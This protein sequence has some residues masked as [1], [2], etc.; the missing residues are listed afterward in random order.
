MKKIALFI[1]LLIVSTEI[2]SFDLGPIDVFERILADD[3]YNGTV[4][5][6]FPTDIY[7]DLSYINTDASFTML[8]D[9]RIYGMLGHTPMYDPF[10]NTTIA[11]KIAQARLEPDNSSSSIILDI[12]DPS[13]K[14]G[15]VFSQGFPGKKASDMI[16]TI[17][18]CRKKPYIHWYRTVGPTVLHIGGNDIN[19]GMDS[20]YKQEG[21][22]WIFRWVL[23]FINNPW[24]FFLNIFTGST[25]NFV[26]A[27]WLWNMEALARKSAYDTG[28]VAYAVAKDNVQPVM[29]VIPAI[30]WHY[31]V[32][33]PNSHELM[34]Q[35]T[36]FV[37]FNSI[38]LTEIAGLFAPYTI[39]PRPLI[40]FQNM[41][42][43]SFDPANYN[44]PIDWVH[45]SDKGNTRWASGI[46]KMMVLKNWFPINPSVGSLSPSNA[47]K[48]D[49]KARENGVSEIDILSSELQTGG[50]YY[51]KDFVRYAAWPFLPYLVRVYTR[52]TD[53]R[54]YWVSWDILS[55]YIEAGETNSTLGFPQSDV[56]L[57]GPFNWDRLIYFENGCI[58]KYNI[59]Y[60]VITPCP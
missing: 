59:T 56:L 35:L 30:A 24:Q 32:G 7:C 19:G 23:D 37:R 16:G 57:W 9:S 42:E 1:F 40:S 41:A 3:N 6:G 14:G 49:D 5:A 33:I 34:R 29:I 20:L 11:T 25:D 18:Y 39:G 46:A 52:D 10:T 28:A 13:F 21:Q 45:F 17:R 58:I 44:V 51:Y 50:T 54:A 8:G 22:Y 48:I 15:R 36:V 43:L 2:Y 47:A 12:N 60:P 53:T 4:S 31:K 26:E 27:W 55:K 38:L